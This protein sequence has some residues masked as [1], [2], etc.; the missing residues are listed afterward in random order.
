MVIG[1]ATMPA[2]REMVHELFNE[3]VFR[4]EGLD[5]EPVGR[6]TE[7]VGNYRI[8]FTRPLPAVIAMIVVT[9]FLANRQVLR[10]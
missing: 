6:I 8:E 4:I 3:D 2:Y 7:K 1:T 9:T 10:V 5:D